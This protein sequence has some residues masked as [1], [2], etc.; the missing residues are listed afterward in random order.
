MSFKLEFW[1]LYRVKF[2]GKG[3]K[4]SADYGLSRCLY[5]ARLLYV[6]SAWYV[7]V[8][9]CR[10]Y[11]ALKPEIWPFAILSHCWR[12]VMP[13]DLEIYCTTT[14]DKHTLVGDRQCLNYVKRSRVGCEDVTFT[15]NIPCKQLKNIHD[16]KINIILS[17]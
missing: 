15:I 17:G 7:S 12:R 2:V 14:F 8:I 13:N 6:C 4:K 11:C 16:K 5:Y 9:Y 3:I 10:S 1:T